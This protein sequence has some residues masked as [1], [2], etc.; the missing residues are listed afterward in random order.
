MHSSLS[1][2]K[3]PGTLRSFSKNVLLVLI[4]IVV[5]LG[6]LEVV[7]RIHNPLGFRI[8]G[9]KIIL[10]INKK[11]VIYHKQSSKLDEVVMHKNNSLGFKGD[12]PPPDFDN[13]LTILAVGGSTTECLEIAPDKSWPH[14]LG[15][16]LRTD[17][18]QLWM[19]NAGLC[20]HS[21]FGHYILIKDYISKLKPKIIIFLVGINEIGISDAREFDTR[22]KGINFRSLDRVLAATANYSEVCA[23]L[24]NLVR[25]FFP[26][27]VVATG[28]RDMGDLDFA[29]LPTMALSASE[30]A[31]IKKTHADNYLPPFAARLENLIKISRDNN[32]EPILLTQPVLYGDVID[33]VTGIDLG[34]IVVANGMNGLIGWDVLELYNE[35]TRKV[36][37]KGNVLVID[38]AREMPKTTRY[39]YDLMH[40]SNQG[41][42]KMADIIDSHLRPYLAGKYPSYC[43]KPGLPAAP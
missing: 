42:E 31:A 36:G 4:S 41:N 39:Y 24:L 15:A 37:Q 16:K 20:G 34:K 28:Q 26:K 13:W 2:T 32:I 43:R 1:P 18:R 3:S 35:T 30:R 17:C 22:L 10:P 33:D 6:I 9:D 14:F 38:A 19:N 5:S 23:A 11:E 21:T 8:K 27:S 29:A 7:L 12:E 40:F 25:Y